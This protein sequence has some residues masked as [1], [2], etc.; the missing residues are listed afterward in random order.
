MFGVLGNAG[1]I[2]VE[3]EQGTFKRLLMA[4]LPKYALLGGK[5]LAQFVIGVLQIALM[6]AFGALVFGVNLGRSIPTLILVTLATC[7]ATTSMGLL[8]VAL[9]K[10]RRQLGPITTMVVLGSAAIGGSWY[11]LFLMPQW[12]QQA[13][14]VTINA[15]SMD[16]YNRLMMFDAGLGDLWLN[17]LALGVYGAVCFGVGLRVFKFKEA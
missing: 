5:L 7:W 17:V 2:L 6:F 12:L 1:S 15:W 9:V 4:P 13:A 11:P 16:A 8:L 10:S 3:K 14:R